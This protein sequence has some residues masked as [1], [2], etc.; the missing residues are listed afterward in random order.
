MLTHSKRFDAIRINTARSVLT[1]ST[2]LVE[3]VLSARGSE[4]AEG[5]SG[6]WWPSGS[7]NLLS[8]L[9]VGLQVPAQGRWS[10]V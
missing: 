6:F 10:S 7:I 5:L 1:A 9:I 3:A 4:L 2:L 8:W